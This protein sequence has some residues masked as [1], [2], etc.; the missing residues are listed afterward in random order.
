MIRIV[1]LLVTCVL[2]VPAQAVDLDEALGRDGGVTGVLWEL[3]SDEAFAQAWLGSVDERQ[4]VLTDTLLSVLRMTEPQLRPLLPDMHVVSDFPSGEGER[5]PD[6]AAVRWAGVRWFRELVGLTGEGRDRRLASELDEAMAGVG[7]P[8]RAEMGGLV[9]MLVL[10]WADRGLDPALTHRQPPRDPAAAA[11]D[12]ARSTSGLP[13]L[14]LLQ[15]MDADPV[16]RERVLQR[17]DL[18][19]SAWLARDFMLVVEVEA[20]SLRTLGVPERR[21]D[22]DTGIMRGHSTTALRRLALDALDQCA[23]AVVAPEQD[24]ARR[25][26]RLAWWD[27][28][29]FEARY[30]PDPRQAPDFGAF[31]LGLGR[32]VSEGGR[33][34]M[35]WTRLIYLQS[36]R[37]RERILEQ[38][39]PAQE[40]AVAELLG[41][42]ALERADAAEA[43]FNLVYTRRPLAQ[44]EGTRRVT[45]AIDWRQVQELIREMLVAITGVEPPPVLA[46]APESLAAWWANWWAAEREDPRWSRGPVPEV[47]QLP[48]SGP[49]LDLDPQRGRVD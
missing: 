3:A 19:D 15:E 4:L 39:G 49:R 21:W 48:D 20:D 37:T 2:A 43:G 23:P 34:P 11:L 22:A 5:S 10:W 31:L 1:T 47:L 24:L 27:D 35:R 44:A 32:P 36:P 12:R 28:A 41:L 7:R 46:A 8:Q 38:L 40:G 9:E 13:G 16:V 26:A 30:W 45:V 25:I 18:A 6:W 42:A 14:A 33:D 17:L 29:R